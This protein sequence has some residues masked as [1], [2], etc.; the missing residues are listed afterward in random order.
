M[1][2]YTTMQ[3]LYTAA[4]IISD[5]CKAD[6]YRSTTVSRESSRKCKYR[7]ALISILP[8]R[9]CR[10]SPQKAE[11]SILELALYCNST[12]RTSTSTIRSFF[13]LQKRMVPPLS[14]P[15][16]PQNPLLR[17]EPSE[18]PTS[19]HSY[20]PIGEGLGSIVAICSVTMTDE[21]F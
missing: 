20:L 6:F 9:T 14:A 3:P 12:S 1:Y 16:Y 10:A 21:Q 7:R 17:R 15:D 5:S 11:I 18:M 13:A 19:R 2:Q 8:H 4:L